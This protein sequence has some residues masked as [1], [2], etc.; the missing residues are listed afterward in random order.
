MQTTANIIFI[1]VA[2]KRFFKVFLNKG[3]LV[4]VL[5]SSLGK[6]H[7]YLGNSA[8]WKFLNDFLISAVY[9]TEVY[10]IVCTQFI[11]NVHNSKLHIYIY[12]KIQLHNKKSISYYF[13]TQIGYFSKIH[14]LSYNIYVCSSNFFNYLFVSSSIKLRIQLVF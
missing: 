8:K 9:T 6:L 7:Q 3:L 2:E 14:C 12:K 4:K 13:N 10:S 1:E 11:K 5:C